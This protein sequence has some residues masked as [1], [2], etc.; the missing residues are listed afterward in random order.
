MHQQ[1]WYRAG[2]AAPLMNEMDPDAIHVGTE[3][4]EGIQISLLLLP[5]ERVAPIVAK[6][7]Q[8]LRIG[9]ILPTSAFDAVRPARSTQAVLYIVQDRS[10]HLDLKRLD[11]HD[12][13]SL[14]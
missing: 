8:I 13:N 11:G 5:V 9:A 3:M 12:M 4:P 1:N 10:L 7:L 14:G 6:L 2:T